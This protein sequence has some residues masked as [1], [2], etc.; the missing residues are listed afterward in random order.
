[1]SDF[2]DTV[3][4][5]ASGKYSVVSGS[6]AV[7][8][9]DLC[10]L[11]F[12]AAAGHMASNY[13][14]FRNCSCWLTRVLRP[15][16]CECVKGQCFHA[17]AHVTAVLAQVAAPQTMQYARTGPRTIPM[18]TLTAPSGMQRLFECIKMCSRGALK[19]ARYKLQFA[20]FGSGNDCVSPIWQVCK[21]LSMHL[22]CGPGSDG[23]FCRAWLQRACRG[24]VELAGFVRGD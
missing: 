24:G 5:C 21:A 22:R 1:M 19:S 10:V 14:M 15:C 13:A 20:V 4:D 7:C 16:Q 18:H 3:V 2:R 17:D 9:R 11:F 23:R 12:P 6:P 8:F